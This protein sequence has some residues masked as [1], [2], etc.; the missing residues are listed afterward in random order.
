MTDTGGTLD[1]EVD[2]T[3]PAIITKIV[4]D[5]YPNIIQTLMTE[6][7]QNAL[8]SHRLA[9]STRKIDITLP[10]TSNRFYYEVRDYG[11]GMTPEEIKNVFR[12]IFRSTKRDSDSL[13]GGFGLG[14]MVFGPYA[15][16]MHVNLFSGTQ[17]DEYVLHMDPSQAKIVHVASRPSDQPKGVG[18]RIPTNKG[19]A[20]RFVL[21]A[22]TIYYALEEEVNVKEGGLPDTPGLVQTAWEEY[23]NRRS[24]LEVDASG[25]K[26]EIS[27]IHNSSLEIASTGLALFLGSLPFSIKPSN[28]SES[29]CKKIQALQAVILECEAHAPAV[30]IFISAEPGAFPVVPA[31]TDIKYID[32]AGQRIVVALTR[33]AEK[34]VEDRAEDMADGFRA[35]AKMTHK[36]F[37]PVLNLLQNNGPL[38]RACVAAGIKPPE[39]HDAPD[40]GRLFYGYC[41]RMRVYAVA[42][43]L[44]PGRETASSSMFR[45]A[46][47]AAHTPDPTASQAPWAPEDT[48]EPPL[49]RMQTARGNPPDGRLQLFERCVREDGDVFMLDRFFNKAGNGWLRDALRVLTHV[50][51]IHTLRARD[52]SYSPSR[53]LFTWADWGGT[54]DIPPLGEKPPKILPGLMAPRTDYVQRSFYYD[55][56]E[57]H[58]MDI[59]GSPRIVNTSFVPVLLSLLMFHDVDMLA[60]FYKQ[61]KR[62][63]GVQRR[64]NAL[65]Q[66][67]AQDYGEDYPHSYRAPILVEL[68]LEPAEFFKKLK[69]LGVYVPERQW[70]FPDAEVLPKREKKARKSIGVSQ[71]L[72]YTGSEPIPWDI[73]IEQS[74]YAPPPEWLKTLIKTVPNSTMFTVRTPMGAMRKR[75][76]DIPT[77]PH[78]KMSNLTFLT[79]CAMYGGHSPFT[80]V[81]NVSTEENIPDDQ[82]NAYKLI[83]A[84]ATLSKSWELIRAPAQNSLKVELALRH[85]KTK[86]VFAFLP[87]ITPVRP[88]NHMKVTQVLYPKEWKSGVVVPYVAV[89]LLEACSLLEHRCALITAPFKSEAIT[90]I[91]KLKDAFGQDVLEAYRALRIAGLQAKVHQ[92]SHVPRCDGNNI[93]WAVFRS[94]NGYTAPLLGSS[95][96]RFDMYI[97]NYEDEKCQEIRPVSRD[98][99]APV[100]MDTTDSLPWLELTQKLLGGVPHLVQFSLAD[101]HKQCTGLVKG[102]EDVSPL[103]LMIR[104][105]RVLRLAYLSTLVTPAQ[106]DEATQ[107]MPIFDKW[108]GVEPG[109][110]FVH[111]H[112]T[113]HNRLFDGETKLGL[114]RFFLEEGALPLEC[115]NRHTVPHLVPNL[116]ALALWHGMAT[117]KEFAALKNLDFGLL[118]WL[119]C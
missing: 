116:N 76:Y 87:D 1:F 74:K 15:G 105:R 80:P 18:I 5:M 71:W 111:G 60:A 92:S 36:S 63:I 70:D 7:V 20:S 48:G 88:L 14:K 29:L 69:S 35:A 40:L 23:K 9:K 79:S 41:D 45:A 37:I 55:N 16:M 119:N 100:G 82:I 44:P 75:G 28:F 115:T 22:P 93:K 43:S 47:D 117:R 72:T 4:S 56:R 67:L 77:H 85:V 38:L 106:L 32:K 73:R 27:Y 112:Q 30:K 11:V 50:K 97:G 10:H 89:I 54:R 6:Y 66:K 17:V 68:D 49:D 109:R 83:H 46:I 81:V 114:A 107:P 26:M 24:S 86:K 25:H 108:P 34:L 96:A 113:L 2:A 3:N 91:R 118:P 98:H 57:H 21:L 12:F 94:Q 65:H 103:M 110:W 59:H 13:A 78:M 64:G 51:Q 8:D 101:R 84:Q 52:K 95:D 62:R 33:L 99:P 42:M 39:V 31:R 104:L 102:A 19:D 90:L 58:K 53:Q 61:P